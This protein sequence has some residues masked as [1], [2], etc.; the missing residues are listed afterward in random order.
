M[1]GAPKLWLLQSRGYCGSWAA[2][3][4]KPAEATVNPWLESESESELSIILGVVVVVV[5]HYSLGIV[6]HLLDP[7]FILI[8]SIVNWQTLGYWSRL[9]VILINFPICVK[10]NNDHTSIHELLT[11]LFFFFPAGLRNTRPLGPLPSRG[12]L[13]EI[14][15]L[16][17]WPSPF[18]QERTTLYHHR[19][20]SKAHEIS[21]GKFTARWQV[22][23]NG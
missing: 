23:R 21:E 9:R 3:G 5:V 15:G 16:L 17:L 14:S 10:N 1:A 22:F 11:M 7:Y 6:S 19:G 12:I 13:I 18:R 20:W 4:G 2:K 8:Y